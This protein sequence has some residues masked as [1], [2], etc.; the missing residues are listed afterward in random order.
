[1]SNFCTWSALFFVP[2]YLQRLQLR[3]EIRECDYRMRVLFSARGNIVG[4]AIIM[5]DDTPRI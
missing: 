2:G 4:V 3:H 5:V 1:M